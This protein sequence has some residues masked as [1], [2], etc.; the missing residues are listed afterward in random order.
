MSSRIVRTLGVAMMT[1][2][3][4]RSAEGAA[5]TPSLS[6]YRLHIDPVISPPGIVVATVDQA[7]LEERCKDNDGCELILS[8][9]ASP[10]IPM[11]VLHGR[12]VTGPI[13]WSIDGA[14]YID[15]DGIVSVGLSVT[16]GNPDSP[17]GFCSFS[18]ADSA[19]GLDATQ[20]FSVKS[21][22]VTANYVVYCT[23][24]VID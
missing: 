19:G 13:G 7:L 24:T 18:D 8:G 12:F 3:L 22:S 1:C 15:G 5:N 17:L 4:T 23:L 10:T 14:S 16:V 6:R 20:A 11:V 2:A 9:S 21:N